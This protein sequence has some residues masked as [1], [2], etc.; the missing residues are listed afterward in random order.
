VAKRGSINKAA[1]IEI[2][3]DICRCDWKVHGTYT[4]KSACGAWITASLKVP[5]G[6]SS[7]VGA[8]T[9]PPFWFTADWGVAADQKENLRPLSGSW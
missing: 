2:S 7:C 4:D 1:A 3:A 8:P 6:V 9:H 5:S